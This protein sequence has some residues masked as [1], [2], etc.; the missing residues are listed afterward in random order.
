MLFCEFSGVG[1]TDTGLPSDQYKRAVLRHPPSRFSVDF[2]TSLSKSSGSYNHGM[3]ISPVGGDKLSVSSRGSSQL[4]Y[5]IW[6]RWEDCLWFQETLELEYKRAAREKKTRLAQ[7]KGVKS[8][9]GMYKQDMASSWESLPPGPDPNS[10]AQDIHD[11]LPRLTKKG[12]VFR[13]SQSTIEMRQ[14]EFRNLVETLFADDMP[15]LIQEIRASNVVTDFFGL[16]RRD[17]DVLEISRKGQARN[18]LTSSIFSS[19]FSS[20]TPSLDE[21]TSP[22]NS[23]RSLPSSPAKKGSRRPRTSSGS[24]SSSRASEISEELRY[25]SSRRLS[26]TSDQT[27]LGH[28]SR[29]RA[30]SVVSS[31]S[32]SAHS[33][34]SSDSSSTTSTTSTTPAIAGDN[35]ILFGHNPLLVND[36]PTS[37]LEVLPEEREMLSKSPESYL[38]SSVW[39][40]TRASPMERKANRITQ[41]VGTPPKISEDQKSVFE[42]KSE[43]RTVRE[44]WQTTASTD[45]TA[46]AFLDGLEFSLPNAIKEQKYRASMASISTFMTTDSADAVVP[47]SPTT[48]SPNGRFS[49]PPRPRISVPISMSDF[50]IY[51]DVDDDSTSILDA[52]PRPTSYLPERPETPLGTEFTSPESP[53]S[54]RTW[55]EAPPSP[56]A[57]VSTFATST[58][59]IS[60]NNASLSPSGSLSIKAAHGTSIILLRISREITLCELRQRLYN[61]FVGQEGVPLSQTFCVAFV[62]PTPVSPNHG[63]LRSAS[64]SSADRME[65]Q[66]INSESE[67]EHLV[68][69]IEGQKITLRILDAPQA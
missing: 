30:D 1:Q 17:F 47:R 16:W 14:R 29:R 37:I 50:D 23:M 54:S 52:F 2:L 68:S 33:D 26:S 46:S 38:S 43:T 4:E 15:A 21:P 44:S 35:P 36:R 19:Y 59:T 32:S 5:D 49:S 13:A 65:L 61:K 10:V 42:D 48:P 67:W 66:F 57:T 40:K 39:R 22:E 41:I 63:R 11:H 25:P 27:T 31:D 3:R 9:N 55:F 6:R 56:T 60:T 18:S 69:T 34:G 28:R 58:W 20:S 45:S 7:G 64:T 53:D 8:Y 12:T 62:P 24:G 51:S